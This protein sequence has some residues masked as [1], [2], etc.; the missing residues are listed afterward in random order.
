MSRKA[1]SFMAAAMIAVA[2]TV[3]SLALAE[4]RLVRLLHLK[5]GDLY[6][7][8]VPA[9]AVRDVV[10]IVVD[11]KS[12][13]VFP[14]PLLFWHGYYA[15]AIEAAAAGGAKVMG[16]DIAFPIPVEQ[17]APGLDQRLAQAVLA[18]APVM[19]VVCG[20][21]PGT[22]A[23]QRRW[24]VP[25]NMAAAA[26]DQMAYVNLRADEDDFIRSVELYDAAGARSL[27]MAMAE[28]FTGRALRPA[29]PA[30]L[31]RY[32][33]P[34]GTFARVSFS[35]FVGAA[36]AGKS[37]QVRQWV[38]GKAVM[39]GTDLITDR[40]ATPFY[41]FRVGAPANTA[42]VEI[43][44][45]A[46]WTLLHARPLGRMSAAG[47]LGAGLGVAIAAALLV[48]AVTGWA[49][50]VSV[51][52]LGA[53]CAGAG[54]ALFQAGRLVAPTELALPMLV[55]LFLSIAYQYFSAARGREAFRR[56]V[57]VF[58]GRQV[59]DTLD[60]TGAY[61]LAGRRENVT[62][63]FS[64][65]RGF[66]AW[67]DRQEPEAVVAR[68]NEY[69]AGMTGCIVRHGGE[70]NKFIGDGI[71]AIFSGEDHPLRAVRCA[72]EMIRQPG[73]FRTGVGLHSGD[74]VVGN[75]GSGDKMDY[76]ALG[77]TVNLAAR[78]EG[79]NKEWQTQIMMSEAT[80][81]CVRSE[82]KARRVGEVAVRGKSAQQAI[83]TIA[84]E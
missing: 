58:V 52:A 34:A 57:R 62:I 70:V 4:T 36:R 42:G 82:V 6:F 25:L 50:V 66:T 48:F 39:L 23:N 79:L 11:Q 17:W 19:P 26:L 51:A 9:E 76:T 35:D 61:S 73:E 44:A 64:D 56:A 81:A 15:E 78:L 18:A 28:R 21:A 55:S 71:L 2:A 67:C 8:L 7:L 29:E 83:Y 13:D 1:R 24:P 3:L 37:A 41:A 40:H 72:M 43:H 16:L 31:I 47:V 22:L 12:L 46:I 75:M 59:A 30:M 33:G 45:N 32:A 5:S 14:E 27:S 49:L 80:W 54:Y 74:A 65:I 84:E 77:D 69:F 10:L 53:A 68:L 20:Y 38:E 63:L 60:E